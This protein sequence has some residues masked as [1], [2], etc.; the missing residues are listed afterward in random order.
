ML[1]R[2][3]HGGNFLGCDAETEAACASVAWAVELVGTARHCF[4][5]AAGGGS[6]AVG[7][8]F[9]LLFEGRGL[10]FFSQGA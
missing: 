10:W 4:F 6:R 9:L 1:F 5:A 2:S 8:R 3:G 7:V